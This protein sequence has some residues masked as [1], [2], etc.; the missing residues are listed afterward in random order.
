MR[1]SIGWLFLT[2]LVLTGCSEP[3]ETAKTKIPTADTAKTVGKSAAT[4]PTESRAVVSASSVEN[5]FGGLSDKQCRGQADG[6]RCKMA[7]AAMADG[8]KK[9]GH[10]TGQAKVDCVMTEMVK[11]DP[12]RLCP[13]QEAGE[14][15]RK[16][17]MAIRSTLQHSAK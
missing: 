2:A 1:I 4:A 11:H 3:H 6:E 15:C 7:M 12:N 9:C 14:G 10:L 13:P 17:V 8:Q 5:P 16:S